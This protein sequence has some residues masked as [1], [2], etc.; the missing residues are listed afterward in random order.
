MTG[1]EVWHTYSQVTNEKFGGGGEGGLWKME[2]Q[3]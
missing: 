3:N 1:Y 2:L